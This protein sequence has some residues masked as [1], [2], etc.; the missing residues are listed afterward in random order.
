VN[1]Y[2]ERSVIGDLNNDRIPDIMT[3]GKLSTGV[4]VLQGKG[5]GQ[6][7]SAKTMFENIPVN[8][9]SLIAVNGDQSDRCGRP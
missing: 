5:N 6:F 9:L 3:F 8:D 1:F 4:S 2:P 7:L